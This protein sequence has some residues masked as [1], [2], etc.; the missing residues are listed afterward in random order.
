MQRP[1]SPAFLCGLVFLAAAAPLSAQQVLLFDFGGGNTTTK[2]PVPADPVNA[3]NNITGAIATVDPAL[4][5]A[6]L[7]AAVTTAGAAT[8]ISLVMV[9]RF[10]GV[11]EGGTQVSGTFPVA[12]TRDSFYGNTEAFNGV[13]NIF[14][15]FKLTGLDPALNHKLTFYASRSGGTEIR[16]T[17]YTV[18]GATTA[19]TS[20]DAANNIDNTAAVVSIKP[21]AA[22]EL[23]VR[24]T[25]GPTNNTG[26]H[27]T[28]L[29]AMRVES[30]TDT[31][32]ALTFSP[33]PADVTVAPGNPVLFTA[34]V[35]G[36]PPYSVQ[37][38]M[39]GEDIP[40]ATQWH[41]AL[42]PVFADSNNTRYSV[43]VSNL[44]FTA[45]SPDAVLRV[46]DDLIPPTIT[47]SSAPGPWQIRLVFSEEL[48]ESSAE[49]VSGYLVNGGETF[50]TAA[51]LLPDRR[52]VVLTP[53]DRLPATPVSVAVSNATDLAGNPVAA[54]TT[55]NVTVERQPDG[56]TLLLDF[57]GGDTTQAG[58][59]N[60][61]PVNRWN[62]ITGTFAAADGAMLTDLLKND[63]TPTP[64]SLS[65]VSRF[66][67][68]NTD[69]TLTSP[70]FPADATRDSLYGNTESFNNLV[71]VTPVFKLGGL[72][73]A[74]VYDLEFF[75]SRMNVADNR[76]TRYTV[77]GASVETRDLN[78]ANNVSN[79]VTVTGMAPD[80][81]GEISIALTPGPNNT[82][83]TNHFIYLGVMKITPRAAAVG[84]EVVMLAPT[85]SNGKIVVNW[86]G[87][88]TL[89]WST[90]LT[91]TWTPVS[92]APAP[93]YS[94]DIVVGQRK[95]FR[96]RP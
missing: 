3:W 28:Y 41:Y 64:L 26:N 36:T 81:N 13:S 37:W 47:S 84:G 20:L 68:A 60:D 38:L 14:P 15:V 35:S 76:E 33:P 83:V 63:D 46:N 21:T 70:L 58:G 44:Q 25:A 31:Q 1:I 32:T 57:G 23:T 34:G 12:A 62:N 49:D 61:D 45:T 50:L 92:P 67:A 88:G 80:V 4:P 82:N 90:T 42:P 86:T 74:E 66:N 27:F 89:E 95:F 7:N 85:V 16:E 72:N 43:R 11:N 40:G 9:S 5:A 18:E 87:T 51:D 65:I 52:T 30:Y 56:K 22:G 77:T 71:N 29:G 54:N 6:R 78:A 10:N 94:E 59:V 79:T 2:G 73:A 53:G 19:D 17:V 24:L 39:N 8:G 69:G 93:P 75:A 48:E 55:V 91:G 96:V